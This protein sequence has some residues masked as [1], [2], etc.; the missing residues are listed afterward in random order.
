MF[1]EYQNYKISDNNTSIDLADI[2]I[3]DTILE[4]NHI[5]ELY[6]NGSKSLEYL[7]SHFGLVVS[8]KF[9]FGNQNENL[10]FPSHYKKK[11][12]LDNGSNWNHLRVYGQLRTFEEEISVTDVIYLPVRLDGK[13][14]SLQHSQDLSIINRYYEYDPDVEENADIFFHDIL[15]KEVDWKEIGLNSLKYEATKEE[16]TDDNYISFKIIT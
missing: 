6:Y 15:T 4:E 13:Y 1:N 2:L 5:Y 12:I 16:M 9:D 10:E 14:K 8:S 7:E 3:F 11:L